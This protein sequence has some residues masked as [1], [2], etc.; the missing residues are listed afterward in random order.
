MKFLAKNNLLYTLYKFSFGDNCL[1]LY[2]MMRSIGVYITEKDKKQET[3]EYK[4]MQYLYCS[5]SM[6]LI[7]MRRAALSLNLVLE[8]YTRKIPLVIYGDGHTI[9]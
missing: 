4:Y 9:A 7:P 5:L 3:L 8:I 2:D 1:L 6:K